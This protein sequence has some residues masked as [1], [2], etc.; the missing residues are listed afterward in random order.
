[1]TTIITISN[2]K[3]GVGKTTTAAHL[4]QALANLGK[5]VLLIDFDPQA[6]LTIL[7]GAQCSDAASY[8]LT[9]GL[10][11][12]ETSLIQNLVVPVR[13]RLS[14]LPASAGLS[15]AQAQINASGRGIDWVR[16]VL[17]RFLRHDLHYIIIDTNPSAS[18]I[19]ERAI[20][21]A[22]L[23][24]I[25]TQAEGLSVSGVSS[26][27]KLAH[28]LNTQYTWQGRVF[29]VLPTM[30]RA[31][32]SNTMPREHRAAL[33]EMREAFGK[34]LLPVIPDRAAVKQCAGF[35]RTLFEFDPDNAA[36]QA[37]LQ[38]AKK[39]RSATQ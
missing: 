10:G 12:A 6:N 34:L 27:L 4:G 3:G 14:L 31:D 20:W 28:T 19:Q 18:G 15:G 38:L 9:L 2:H 22:D 39:I 23:L 11:Q 1:M 7:F 32:G 33:D 37:Y 24:I 21:A 17:Q 35:S 29:G 16:Q 26:M 25:P 13:E 5:N 8:L 36:A 30:V